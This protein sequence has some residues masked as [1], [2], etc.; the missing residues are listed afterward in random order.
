MT[1]IKVTLREDGKYELSQ[2][3]DTVVTFP[4]RATLT[5]DGNSIVIELD[6][7]VE[8]NPDDK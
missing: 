2:P 8:K 4:A 5:I 1:K 7:A 6:Q 3:K